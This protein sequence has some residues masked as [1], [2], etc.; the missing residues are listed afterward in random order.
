MTHNS[1]KKNKMKE[2]VINR[3]YGGFG[4]SDEAFELYLKKKG[5]KFYRYPTEYSSFTGDDFYAVPKEKYEALK[6]EVELLDKNYK[7]LN[8][9]NWFLTC[10]DIKRDDPILI[11]VVKTLKK[12]ANTRTSNLKVVKIPADVQFE[13]DEYDGLE[14]IHEVHRSW[15]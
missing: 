6:E 13:I 5:Q 4:L 8:E 9:K 11:E 7:R 14:S 3:C 10:Y 12:K 1:N 15:S 2:V